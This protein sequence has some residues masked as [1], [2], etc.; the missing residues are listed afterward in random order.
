MSR[1]PR[2]VV[3]HLL[4]SVSLLAVLI[5]L[6][7]P[8]SADYPLCNAD[9]SCAWPETC[10]TCPAECGS[11]DVTTRTTQT[12]RYVD[13]ACEHH[14][15]GSADSCAAGPGQPGRFQD[16][17][18]A[19]E[20]LTAGD[21]LFIHPGD[22][23]REGQAYGGPDDLQ[24]HGTADAP[25]VLTAADRDNPPTLHSWDPAAPDNAGSHNA[26]ALAG[27]HVIVDHLRIAGSASVGGTSVQLQYL[28][29]SHG[30]EGCDGNWSCLRIEWCT[31]C[32]VHH[33]YV[34]DV[35]DH[36]N[37]CDG[38]WD[39]REAGFKEFNGERN[40]WE[41]NTVV[42]A[43]RWAYDLHR[44]SVDTIVRFNQLSD[45]GSWAINIER[46]TNTQIY[47]NLMFGVAGCMEVGGLNEQQQGQ[48]HQDLIHHNTCWLAGAGYH[49]GGDIQATLTDNIAASL[50]PGSSDTVNVEL[51]G[52][53]MDAADCNAWDDNSWYSSEL[54]ETY[55]HSFAD[56]QA[57]TD[58]DA[59]S[60]AAPGG[61]CAFV[62]PP[63]SG[64]DLEFDLHVAPATAC[65]TAACDGG[66][67]GAYGI[68]PCVGHTCGDV[69]GPS[70][71]AGGSGASSAGSGGGA[72]SAGGSG[73]ESASGDAGSGAATGSP[74][75]DR[76]DG[77]G[78]SCSAASRGGHGASALCALAL[79]A[80]LRRRRKAISSSRAR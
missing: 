41:F 70:S 78:C 1:A 54:Y 72:Q 18:A 49:L 62:D 11:C 37:H 52:A 51:S 6:S 68:T 45:T 44:N 24:L 36:T 21:T 34:H 26:L 64:L 61:A 71:G 32:V 77:G 17:Q 38:E 27:E 50:D 22:Y 74:A 39:P 66:E 15:D 20:S 5:S 13:G 43:T 46:A 67:L 31:D 30:W 3:R 53:T 57:G 7:T 58:F 2:C 14:G 28:E 19:I 10:G 23:F 8:A 12:A 47:G 63:E 25:I 73:A 65:A 76:G 80:L 29:C 42:T 4:P 35:V 69:P 75:D 33:N 79:A 56:W 9:G 55:F 48:P 60:I 40:I 59:N 16:L